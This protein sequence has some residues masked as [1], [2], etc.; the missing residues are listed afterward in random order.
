MMEKA[1]AIKYDENLPAP[2]VLAKGRGFLA[3]EIIRIA[4]KAGV[5]VMSHPDLAERLFYLETGSFI[6]EECFGLVAE[7]LVYVHNIS[8]GIK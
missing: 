8:Q 4:R 3:E 7:M 1:V 2:F 6:P 5:P